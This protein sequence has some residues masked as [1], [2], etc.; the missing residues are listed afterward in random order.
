MLSGC[1]GDGGDRSSSTSDSFS[2]LER[3]QASLRDGVDDMPPVQET[4]RAGSSAALGGGT[5]SY[6]SYSVSA[7]AWPELYT[8]LVRR[9][10]EMGFA[11]TVPESA[12]K[13]PAESTDPRSFRDRS[14]KVMAAVVYAPPGEG[15]E[16]NSTDVTGGGS[17]PHV[18]VSFSQSS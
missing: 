18:L 16:V 6:A 7:K 10:G 13:P 2:H 9:L 8:S 15:F 3:L 5:H 11:S 1:W 14:G 12:S 17:G 4:A